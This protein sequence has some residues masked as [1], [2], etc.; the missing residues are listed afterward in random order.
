MP[1]L[2][3]PLCSEATLL[4]EDQ[5]LV[6]RCS[7][8]ARTTRA[9]ADAHAPTL[10]RAPTGARA[11]THAVL[12][13]PLYICFEIYVEVEVVGVKVVGGGCGVCVLGA[14]GVGTSNG[15]IRQRAI[16]L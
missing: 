6:H 3:D 5:I 1:K 16:S 10:T 7:R 4:V 11:D 15:C 13:D 12:W 14:Q 9:R 2:S 8:H